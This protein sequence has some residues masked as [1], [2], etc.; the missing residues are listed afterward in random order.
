MELLGGQALTDWKKTIKQRIDGKSI[1]GKRGGRGMDVNQEDRE[2]DL[3][4]KSKQGNLE[5][6][7][8]LV[9][10]YEK[11][12]YNVAYRFIGNHDDASDLAQEA[13]V[14]AF[15]SIKSFR[16]EASLKTWLYHIV[17]NVCR[18]ELRKRKRQPVVS[19]DAPIITEDGEMHRQQED[20]SFAPE[21]IYERIEVQETV[22]QLLGELI[23]EYRLVLIMREIQGFTYE[24]IATQLGCSLGTVKSRINRARHALKNKIMENQ[25]L[26]HDKPRL[27][28]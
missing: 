17:A 9:I 15:K 4:E 16:G 5:A 24:E 27:V 23:P 25:E 7:E 18:D 19:L 2:Q 6:F 28:R 22:Q 10:L 1:T 21:R 8:E 14:R 12:I 11:Q 20:W 13:F 3:I 26:F